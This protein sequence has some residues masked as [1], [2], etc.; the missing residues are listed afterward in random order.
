MKLRSLMLAGAM[1]LSPVLAFAADPILSVGFVVKSALEGKVSAVD[2]KTRT[3][4]LVGDKGNWLALQVGP[5]VKNLD[6]VKVGDK[7]VAGMEQTTEILVVHP[8]DGTPLP[9]DVQTLDVA[10]KG[11]KPGMIVTDRREVA[12]TITALNAETRVV[13]LQ[14]PDGRTVDLKVPGEQDGF[15]KLNVGDHVIF[16]QVTVAGLMDVGSK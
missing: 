12:A 3:L 2:A 10:P 11:A 6:Q 16:R 7:V 14:G 1:M 5:E 15:K 8:N 13:T 4:T 9:T